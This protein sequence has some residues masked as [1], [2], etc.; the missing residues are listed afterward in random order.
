MT[1]TVSFTDLLDRAVTDPGIVSDAY[2]SSTATASGISSW[3]S[4]SA[5]SEGFSQDRW[6]PIPSGKNSAAR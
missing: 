5:T 4:S 1:P 3:P 2:R 6:R